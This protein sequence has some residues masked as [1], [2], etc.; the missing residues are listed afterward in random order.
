M[1]TKPFS[2]RPR[3][4]SA[5]PCA[6]LVLCAAL[7]AAPAIA[8]GD[9]SSEISRL[10][11]SG[12]LAEA[13]KR[14]DAGLA[15]KPADARLRFSKGIILAQQNKPTEA[16]AVLL[17][18]TEDFPDLPEPYNNLAVLYAANGQYESARIALDKAIASNPGYGMAHENLGDVYAELASQAYEKAARIDGSAGAK[19]KVAAI[20][21]SVQG[22]APGI[23]ARQAP[24]QQQQ[25]GRNVLAAADTSTAAPAPAAQA[26][27]TPAA[28]AADP[29]RDAE[30][31][32]VLAAVNA[33]AGAWS[34]RDVKAYLDFYSADFVV[35]RGMSR[36]K[37]TAE[38]TDR[39]TGKQRISVKIEAPK[40]RLDGDRATVQF[41]QEFSSD[42]LKSTDQKTLTLVK[43]DGAWRIREERV[44]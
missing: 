24:Q 38:R 34:A 18:L 15:Q 30:Q 29:D 2:V 31:A 14:V 27:K 32:A 3:S 23:V 16:I 13:M 12:Q 40:V 5:L 39:I 7:F 17:K 44:G 22:A 37:W 35:P 25:T 9:E 36:D 26:A 33:W 1:S 19:A 11:Q 41:R 20:R 6:A 43:R 28:K 8:A 42:K 10:V 4:I 21:N